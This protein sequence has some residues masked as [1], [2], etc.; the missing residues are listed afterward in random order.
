MADLI[1]PTH[2]GEAL[3]VARESGIPLADVLDFSAS[4]NPL[5]MPEGV[6]P[7]VLAA[8]DECI[9]Y[10]EAHGASLIEALADFH[11]IA[12]QRLLVGNG[13]T[14]LIYLLPRVLRP[15]RAALV[16]PAFSE[17]AKA[18]AQIDCPVDLIP[19]AADDDFQFD[20]ERIVAALAE[21]V[22]LVW[23]ANPGNPSGALIAVDA[24]C[25]LL[26]LLPEGVRVVLDEA[27]IDFA[28]D[29]SFVAQA[30]EYPQLMMLR[31]M[32][33]FYAIPG[34]RVGYLLA[35]PELIATLHDAQP[36]WSLSTPALAA[37]KACLRDADYRQ[38]TLAMM[39]QWREA[40]AKELTA[41]G[42]TVYPAAANYLLV[43]LP[44]AA[45]AASIVAARLRDQGILIRN[46]G[47]FYPL[48]ERMVRV[49]VKTPEDN[50]RLVKALRNQLERKA[51]EH[52]AA[53][54]D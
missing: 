46:C 22:D 23:L 30:T 38:R 39:P 4:I 34:L 48:D 14:E 51:G 6:R 2:G 12:A 5:G 10:P 37:A 15:R 21:N 28:P 32:T 13:S 43:R 53:F 49:A 40:L 27:F 25:H 45:P 33:K 3:R 44:T 42:A 8:L 54:V 24:I 17:Y 31:S 52:N 20:P 7:A 1:I 19:L 16:T 26:E 11:A 29:T 41:L 35:A 9:H 47:N 18:L 36:P 50:G